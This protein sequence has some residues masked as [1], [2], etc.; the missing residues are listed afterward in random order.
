MKNLV[1]M[2]ESFLIVVAQL[3]F[4]SPEVCKQLHLKPFDKKEISMK[5]FGK[6]VLHKNM[7][8]LRLSVKSKD[9]DTKTYINVFVSKICQPI[10]E[11]NINL[12]QNQ[13]TYLVNLDVTGL[14]QVI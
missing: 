8:V 9:S 1:R 10:E 11:Q 14:I 12:A 2:L 5:T 3:N 7:D 13:V 6:A 4:T